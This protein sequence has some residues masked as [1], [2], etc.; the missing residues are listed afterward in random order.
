MPNGLTTFFFFTCN[1]EILSRIFSIYRN[2]SSMLSY[3]S[4][5][6]VIVI[7][8]HRSGTTLLTKI[9]KKCGVFWGLDRDEY[10][11]SKLFQG[12]NED[13]FSMAKCRWDN[14]E[15]VRILLSDPQQFDRAENFIRKFATTFFFDKFFGVHRQSRSQEI[16]IPYFPWGWKD[17]RNTFTI[18]IWQR[19]FP[20]ARV[21]HVL[22]NGID[23]SSS[24]WKRETS[25]PEGSNHPHYSVRCQSLYGCFSLWKSYAGIGR[26]YVFKNENAIEIRFEDIVE[27]PISILHKITDFIG[28][29]MEK[30][31]DHAVSMINPKRSYAYRNDPSLHMFRHK[32]ESD[33]VMVEL[34]YS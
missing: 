30:D 25:R 11:E 21:I 4:T 29:K 16:S 15:P 31:F 27:K 5:S 19:I 6:P 2:I 3:I 33:P 14:P 18:P 28:L 1:I 8:M 23:V 32:V 10:N 7:G 12:L 24:L 26:N 22:R 13:L 9:L 20:R 17:P 34:G